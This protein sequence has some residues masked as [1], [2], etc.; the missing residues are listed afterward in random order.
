MRK[1][2]RRLGWALSAAA[3]LL[4]FWVAAVLGGVAP[5]VATVFAQVH[6]PLLADYRVDSTAAFAPLSP[7]VIKEATADQV[8]VSN[9]WEGGGR[10]PGP[11]PSPSPLP[12]PTLPAPTPTLPIPTPTLPIPTPT[13]PIPTPTL[14]I[15]TPTLP[16]PTPTLPTPVPTLPLPTPPLP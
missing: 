5:D 13:A 2:R 15:P 3:I 1:A 6:G 10:G 11:S 14:P 7:A 8:G 12:S 9:H 16:V 4:L